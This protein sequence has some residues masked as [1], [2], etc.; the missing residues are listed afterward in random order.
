MLPESALPTPAD[1][2]ATKKRF[3]LINRERLARAHVNLRERQ[4]DFLEVLPL[5]FHT[6]H[7]SLPGYVSKNTPAGVAEYRPSDRSME[8]AKRFAK[9]FSQKRRALLRYEI[10]GLYLMGSSGTIAY[11]KKSDFDVWIC[12]RHDI[13]YQGLDELRQKAHAIEQW[14]AELDLEVHFFLVEPSSFGQGVHDDMSAESSGSAQ[15]YLLMEEFYRTGLLLAGRYPFWWVVPPNLE[16]QYDD[17]KELLKQKRFLSENEYID[18]GAMP[19]VPAEEFFGAALWQLYK[20]IDSPYKS[21]LKLMMMEVYAGEYPRVELLCHRFKRS[22]YEGEISLDKLDPYIMLYRKIEEYLMRRGEDERLEMVRR[23]FYFKINEPLSAPEKGREDNWRRNS[24]LELT[25]TWDW[26]KPYLEMLDARSKWKIDRVVRERG[27]LVKALTYSYQFLSDFAREHA[28]LALI[29]QRDLNVLGRKLY[30]AFE[31]KA[32]KVEIVNRGISSNVWES[33]LTF[34]RAVGQDHTEAWLLFNLP[35]NLNELRTARPLRR[36]HSLIELLAWCHFNNMLDNTT[37][38][39]MHSQDSSVTPRELKEM[40]YTFQRLFPADKIMKTEMDDF[41]QQAKAAQSAVF[42]NLGVDP[43]NEGSRG[44]HFLMSDKTDAFS[45]GGLGENLAISFD[46]ITVTTWK[47]VLTSRY[48]GVGG[49][50][51]CVRDYFRWTPIDKGV[52]PPITAHCF[53]FARA[54]TIRHRMEELFADIVKCFYVNEGGPQSR[55]V[56]SIEHQH[57]VLAIENG[58]LV[59]ERA[60]TYAEL[61]R[62]LSAP[63]RVFRPIVMDR[64]ALAQ[65]PLSLILPVNKAQTVQLFVQPVGNDVDVYVLDE[66]GA[67]FYQRMAKTDRVSVLNHFMRFFDA[68][69]H[70]EELVLVG[71]DENGQASVQAEFYE[72]V[73]NPQDRKIYLLRREQLR[74]RGSMVGMNIQVFGAANEGSQQAITIYCDEQEFSSVE[75]GADLYREVGRHVLRR[76]RSGENY[77]IYITDL[78]LPSAFVAGQSGNARIP[79]VTL[80][81]Y[82]RSIERQLTVAVEDQAQKEAAAPNG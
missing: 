16:H 49:L 70:R 69:R 78:D 3:Q 62:L 1:L 66:N 80:L 82:K 39:A 54:V 31:R 53:S 15:H 42:I 57:F 11:S 68:I 64:Y 6:N 43:T 5:L 20:G 60:A 18:F 59:Y 77:P 34:Y 19:G 21:V 23:C 40:W 9:S 26:T 55:Y 37:V 74:A 63:Q 28:Q 38:L 10:L 41:A 72:I 24:L 4:S 30:A 79:T 25:Q 45:Y 67:L 29:N 47:E 22:I 14:A 51:D 8:A 81:N 61:L 46:M 17:Y 7:P 65:T 35:L 50:M 2:S 52:P 56:L 48:V 71:S 73:Q 33:H 12:H 36:S 32:G 75:F 44:G 13:D 58:V 27:V 76:R